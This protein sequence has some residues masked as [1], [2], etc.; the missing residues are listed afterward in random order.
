MLARE[1]VHCVLLRRQL[2]YCLELSFHLMLLHLGHLTGNLP[3]PLRVTQG[4][5]GLLPNPHLVQISLAIV[6]VIIVSILLG[7]G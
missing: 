6:I 5:S 4:S 2:R 3:L 7:I 1:F